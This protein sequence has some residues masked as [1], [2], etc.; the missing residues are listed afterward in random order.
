MS[1][2]IA[3]EAARKDVKI[4]QIPSP[5]GDSG[6]VNE[7]T[8]DNRK[9]CGRF[10]KRGK[11]HARDGNQ[12][13]PLETRSGA[14]AVASQITHRITA[15]TK[16]QSASSAAKQVI[17]SMNILTGSAPLSRRKIDNMSVLQK[18]LRN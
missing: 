17:C 6:G 2:A 3:Q 9:S 11:G 4:L 10:S 8:R 14:S 5:S 1:E 18:I 16:A 13:S 7:E 12:A 15:D